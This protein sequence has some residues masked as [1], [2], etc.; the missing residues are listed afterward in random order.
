MTAQRPSF[1]IKK[2]GYDRFAVDDAV[3]KYIQEIDQLE[4][5]IGLYQQQLVETTG[6]LEAL[7]DQYRDLLRTEEARKGTADEIARLSLR[8]ANEIINTANAN[9]DIIIKEALQSAR[10]ILEDLAM[11][12]QEAGYV[13]LDTKEKL[14]KL[15][16]DLEEF[17]LPE[18]PDISWLKEAENKMR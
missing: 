2:K 11:I 5:K 9:A 7:K 10:G 15:L 12:Y 14:E 3:E 8:E 1:Q 17:N 16:R 6:Q 18:M 13:K 4:R